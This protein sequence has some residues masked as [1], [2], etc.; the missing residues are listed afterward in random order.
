M[1]QQITYIEGETKTVILEELISVAR[2]R[3]INPWY[4][5]DLFVPI[6]K[7]FGLK[8]KQGPIIDYR[9]TLLDGN[10]TECLKISMISRVEVEYTFDNSRKD[11]ISLDQ[12]IDSFIAQTEDGKANKYNFKYGCK[13]RLF[14]SAGRVLCYATHII[15]N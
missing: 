5:Q 9:N 11:Y 7:V 2:I 3:R 8:G 6:Y 15:P 13:I 10:M 12:L 14:N 1:A 4:T